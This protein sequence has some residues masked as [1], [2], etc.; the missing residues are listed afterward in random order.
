MGVLNGWVDTGY[1]RRVNAKEWEEI[2]KK[3]SRSGKGGYVIID[4]DF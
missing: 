1:I 4:F 3:A 2:C